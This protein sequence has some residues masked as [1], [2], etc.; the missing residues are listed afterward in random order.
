MERKQYDRA[1]AMYEEA[2]REYLE[3]GDL[4]SAAGA[5]LGLGQL[6]LARNH[7]V[8]AEEWADEADRLYSPPE[9]RGHMNTALL[10]GD[11]R[12]AR[13]DRDEALTIYA[14][15]LRETDERRMALTRAQALDWLG[16]AAS[17]AEQW[18]QAARICAAAEHLLQ[19]TGACWNRYER[20]RRAAW[21]DRTRQGLGTAR[22]DEVRRCAAERS[23]SV[24]TEIRIEFAAT[25]ES[26]S[27]V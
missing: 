6:A 22:F 14:T 1:Q 9:R 12:L 21:M 8:A 17:A 16:W 25:D 10:R 24:L 13:G 11:A 23:E 20:E 18:E 26:A 4:G 7:L 2:L 19:E 27:G 3:V 5:A 15:I